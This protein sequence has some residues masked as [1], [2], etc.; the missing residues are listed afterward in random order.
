MKSYDVLVIGGGPAGITLAKQLGAKKSIG[1]IRPEEHSMIYCSMPY[2]IEDILPIEK[3]FKKDA[4]VCDSGADL[5]RTAVTGVNF[6]NKEVIC[7]NGR[8]YRYDKLVLAYGAE[9]R[10][11]NIENTSLDG[12]MTFKTSKD[13]EFILQ[14]KSKSL[15]H[16]VVVGAGAIGIE[17]S[18]ALQTAGI[19]TYLVDMADHILSN[20]LDN[21]MVNDVE[22]EIIRSGIN[23]RLGNK[24]VELCGTANVENVVLESGE[25]IRFSGHDGCSDE[26]D[27]DDLKGIVIFA[28]GMKVDDSLL[29]DTNIEFGKDGII[30]N[31]RMETNIH[32][33][34]AAGD[35]VQFY[36]GISGDSISGKLATNAVPMARIC[37]R[38]ILGEERSYPGF[39]NG[40]ATRIGLLYAGGTGLS[41]MLAEK[42]FTI[43]TGHAELT[44]KFPNMPDAGIIRIKIVAD[45]DSHKILGAQVVSRKPVTD[46]IDTITLA[47]QNNLRLE[48]LEQLSY[49]AQP[50]QSFY[51]A[52]NLI[53]AA[54]TEALNKLENM[55][56]VESFIA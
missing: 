32:D 31:E 37:A 34:Y 15:K 17:L 21:D 1:I 30:V 8:I 10:K 9:P 13:L 14:N 49:S 18:L 27:N 24:V 45:A 41:E 50:Y 3:T 7:G 26:M 4:L 36:S 23:L 56:K 28:I 53:V 54:S 11:P 47:I 19:E 16:A 43:I 6:N 55:D 22:E 52:N 40:S 38:N 46:K 29:R 12:V 44:D 48:D 35:C 42:K 20:M 51:P 2:V 25:I 33:V 39:F 5:I